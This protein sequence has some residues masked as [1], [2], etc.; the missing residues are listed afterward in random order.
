MNELCFEHGEIE[1]PIW[2]NDCNHAVT[3]YVASFEVPWVVECVLQMRKYDLY[4]YDS[5]FECNNNTHLCIRYGNEPSEYYS[6]TTILSTARSAHLDDIYAQA[7]CL[8][9]VKGNIIWKRKKQK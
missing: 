4:A 8:L 6:P 3:E 7:L 9:A 5:K 1:G 2:N